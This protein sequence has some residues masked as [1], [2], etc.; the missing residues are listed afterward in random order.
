MESPLRVEAEVEGLRSI[1]N[2][3]HIN[4]VVLEAPIAVY[5]VVD[6]VTRSV[7]RYPDP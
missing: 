6:A 1:P 5:E 4:L 7:S 3:V 2:S